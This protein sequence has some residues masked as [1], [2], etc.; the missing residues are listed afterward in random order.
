MNISTSALRSASHFV[1]K[2]P[3]TFI[4]GSFVVNPTEAND[5][6]IVVPLSTWLTA[7][8]EKIIP[9]AVDI[10]THDDKYNE[11]VQT[12]ALAECWQWGDIQFLAI[13]DDYIPA[14]RAAVQEMLA[15]PELFQERDDRIAA[16]KKHRDV[17]TAAKN[18]RLLAAIL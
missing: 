16:H 11:E 10:L 14:Y 5:I 12:Y 7:C 8:K 3:G 9:N 2:V 18:A 15:N 6:D 17:I 1:S 13:R 4:G